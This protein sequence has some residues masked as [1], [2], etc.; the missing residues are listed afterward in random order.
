MDSR[1]T[2]RRRTVCA[3]ADRAARGSLAR[4]VVQHV[5]VGESGVQVPVGGHEMSQV[6]APLLSVSAALQCSA[7]VCTT[8]TMRTRVR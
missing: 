2:R 4:G 3:A 6:S 7:T 1:V 8:Q 5:A